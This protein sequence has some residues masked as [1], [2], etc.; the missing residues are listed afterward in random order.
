MKKL[1]Y[2]AGYRYL[3]RSPNGMINAHNMEAPPYLEGNGNWV[4]PQI[5]WDCISCDISPEE[6]TI[7][8]DSEELEKT[9]NYDIVKGLIQFGYNYI[10][11]DNENGLYAFEK[12]PCYD[13][14]SGAFYSMGGKVMELHTSLFLSLKRNNMEKLSTKG[15]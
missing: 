12:E 3:K 11:R 9:E 4:K 1:L 15:E 14:Q 6:I 8:A 13:E 2:A 10:A 7:D 5:L